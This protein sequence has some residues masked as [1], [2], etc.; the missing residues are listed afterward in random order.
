MPSHAKKKRST[1]N[2]AHTVIATFQRVVKNK[3]VI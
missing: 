1:N 3:G 2:T